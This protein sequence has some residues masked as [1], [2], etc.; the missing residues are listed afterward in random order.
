MSPKTATC[1]PLEQRLSIVKE[2]ILTHNYAKLAILCNC[3]IRT[4]KRTVAYWKQ[5]GGFEEF[6]MDEFLTSYPNIKEKFPDKAFDRL[7][8]LL[9][10]T[11]THKAEIR[12]EKTFTEK[13]E[14]NI[15]VKLKDYEAAIRK[16]VERDFQLHNNKQPIHSPQADT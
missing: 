11:L 8:F 10:K 16:A 15:S 12:T 4:I 5:Q 14:V 6:L 2:K 7:C 13:K 1:L 3:T 9:G